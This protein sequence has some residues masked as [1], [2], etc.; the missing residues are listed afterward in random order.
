M[1]LTNNQQVKEEIREI[2]IFLEASENRFWYDTFPSDI[3]KAVYS[4]KHLHKKVER[5]Q[6][7]NLAMQLK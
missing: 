5:V 4:T 7:N 6:M 2:K 1:G 3:A